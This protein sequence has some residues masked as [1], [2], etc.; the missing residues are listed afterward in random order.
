MASTTET[1]SCIQC[2]K[3]PGQVMCDGC[4]R[5]FCL[6]HFHEHQLKQILLLD[7]HDRQ[8]PLL[9]RVDRWE[10]RSMK[11]IKQVANEVRQQIKELLDRSKTSIGDTLHRI[12]NEIRENQRT[13]AFTEVDLEKWMGQLHQLR[14]QFEKLPVIKIQHDQDEASS[15]HLRLIQLQI[16]KR[17]RGILRDINEEKI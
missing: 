8:H 15:T 16:I 4:Q 1:K 12:A 17:K 13:E 5:F 9:I 2:P 14:N 7:G 3:G 6:K 10:A 11:R